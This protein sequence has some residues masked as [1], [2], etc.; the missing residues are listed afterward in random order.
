MIVAAPLISSTSKS[1]KNK[2]KLSNPDNTD[3][4]SALLAIIM[5]GLSNNDWNV[6]NQALK[7]I[8]SVGVI[9]A[10]IT[11]KPEID[12]NRNEILAHL[13]RLKYDKISN[14]RSTAISALAIWTEIEKKNNLK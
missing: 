1:N 12:N 11:D 3:Y 10:N 14:V 6:R 8:H 9:F 13:E 2:N 5:D 4:F 7:G